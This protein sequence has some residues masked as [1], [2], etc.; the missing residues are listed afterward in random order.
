M[1][2]NKLF[3]VEG[4]RWLTLPPKKYRKVHFCIVSLGA[5]NSKEGY[6][7]AKNQ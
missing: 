1:L 4:N 2:K 3:M 6:Q 5:P 7:S